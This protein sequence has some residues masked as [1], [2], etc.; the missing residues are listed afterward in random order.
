MTVTSYLRVSDGKGVT[1]IKGRANR[2]ISKQKSMLHGSRK[3]SGEHG[4]PD[5]WIASF[6]FAGQ[7][8]PEQEQL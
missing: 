2:R 7:D 8:T 3:T 4:S 1:F 5:S 6:D